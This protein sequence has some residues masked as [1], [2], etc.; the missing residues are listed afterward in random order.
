MGRLSRKKQ[1]KGD[2]PLKEKYR[3]K[4]KTKD[5]DEIHEDMKPA[6]SQ[7]LLNQEADFDKPGAG[8]FYCLHCA[9]YFI[10]ET[11]LKT[12]FKSKPH[13]RRLKALSIE[14][15][16]IEEAERAAGMGSYKRPEKVTVETQSASMET[17][18]T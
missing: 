1:H 16:T 7:K 17:D 18:N 13:K 6:K 12:H 10:N 11:S 8:Q 9:K 3:T 2:K 5:L 4:R 14:P 15:Y